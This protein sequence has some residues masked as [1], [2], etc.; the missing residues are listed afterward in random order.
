MIFAKL[1]TEMFSQAAQAFQ[2]RG[3]PTLI[4]FK[5]GAEVDR[6][7]GAMPLSTLIKYLARWK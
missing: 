4:V 3:I 5:N 1:D 2:I 6:Q 7:S